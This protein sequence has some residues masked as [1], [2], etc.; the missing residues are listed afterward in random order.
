[1]IQYHQR[2]KLEYIIMIKKRHFLI[3][4]GLLLI[5]LIMGSIFDL[6]IDRALFSEGN[7]FGLIMASFAVYPCYAGLA[8]IGG[9]LLATTIK[10]KE[11]PLW[12][13]I[14]SYALAALA[15]GLSIYLCG[16]ELPS[17]NGFDNEKLAIPSYLI[18][19]VLFAAVAFLAFKVCSKGDAKKYWVACMVMAVIFTVALLPTGFVVKLI[20]HRPRYRYCVDGGITDFY[21]WWETCKDYK[22]II[23]QKTMINGHLID[24]EEFKSFP[25]GHSGTAAIMMMFL[26]YMSIFF[27]KLKGKE[28]LMFYIGFAW[29]LL[30]MFS[31][32]LV[33]AHYLS[34]TCMGSLIVMV[35]YYVVHTFSVSKGWIYKEESPLEESKQDE[36]AV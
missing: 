35:V 21:N 11:L 12:G 28:L 24:K 9:G 16:R 23:E 17:S 8:F 15:Y 25:S 20:L 1:M 4:I 30:M 29:T 13:K 2:Y 18:C 34:D 22:Q 31:R 27:N 14:G 7:T 26:P 19:A 10:R 32:M 36:V 5:G 33:G 6:E 3:V